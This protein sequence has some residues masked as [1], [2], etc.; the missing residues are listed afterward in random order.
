ML[1]ARSREVGRTVYLVSDETCVPTDSPHHVGSAD[2]RSDAQ[3]SKEDRCGSRRS[4]AG[5]PFDEYGVA[6]S[7]DYLGA[8]VQE[9][10]AVDHAVNF[11]AVENGRGSDNRL[12]CVR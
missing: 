10:P 3:V 7:V 9:Y 1:D 5:S 12:P 2:V 6:D 4:A 8:A 11:G